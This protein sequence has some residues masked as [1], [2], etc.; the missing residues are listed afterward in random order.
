M[1]AIP[2]V[3]ASRRSPSALVADTIPFSCVD[4]PGNRF[5]RLP[6]G[7]QLRLRRVPQP[8]HDPGQRRARRSRPAADVGRR[9]GRADRASLRRSSRGVTVSGGEATQQAAFVRDLFTA[10][11]ADPALDRLTCF[12]DSNGACDADDVG[13]ARTGDRR[14]DDR[15][16]VLRPRHPPDADRTAERSGAGQ[17]PSPPRARPAVRGAVAAS[18]PGV[19]DDPDLL[20][21][22]AEWLAAIDPRMRVKLIAFRRTA[23]TPRPAARRTGSAERSTPSPSCSAPSLVRHPPRLSRSSRSHD[24]SKRHWMPEPSPAGRPTKRRPLTSAT[25]SAN[26]WSRPSISHGC[27]SG[28]VPSTKRWCNVAAGDDAP[29]RLLLL[30]DVV[31][32]ERGMTLVLGHRRARRRAK[33]DAMRLSAFRTAG[34]LPGSYR[35][36]ALDDRQ[37]SDPLLAEQPV[38]LP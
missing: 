7:L 14:S 21:R 4:G 3:Q 2:I 18:S 36:S 13:Q 35:I 28:A 30:V 33:Y 32:F 10:I 34:N 37:S 5:V 11:K 16:Q 19:N 9:P 24:Q 1:S 15:P 29:R 23:P 22:T 17:H 8:A 27:G 25:S 12:V 31:D 26:H 20:R 6:A 38:A